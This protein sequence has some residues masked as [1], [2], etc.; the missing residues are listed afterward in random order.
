MDS[1][2]SEIAAGRKRWLNRPS[3][4]KV[5]RN[6]TDSAASLPVACKETLLPQA[7]EGHAIAAQ[8]MDTRGRYRFNVP[9]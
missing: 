9:L 2:S 6:K 5:L 1:F 3:S 4:V 8:I 7:D